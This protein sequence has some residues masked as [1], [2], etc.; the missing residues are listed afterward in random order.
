MRGK[1][2]STV[3]NSGRIKLDQREGRWTWKLVK[4][5]DCEDG[6]QIREALNQGFRYH[7]CAPCATHLLEKR[8][9]LGHADPVLLFAS[10]GIAGIRGERVHYRAG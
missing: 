3:L 1:V 5:I 10:T 7:R 8:I 4:C 6:F 9:A 2:P